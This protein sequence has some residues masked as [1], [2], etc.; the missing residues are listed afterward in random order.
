MF[1]CAGQR[2]LDDPVT[3]Q[4]DLPGQVTRGPLDVQPRGQPRLLAPLE[5]IHGIGQTA[6]VGPQHAV[7][8]FDQQMLRLLG[9]SPFSAMHDRCRGEQDDDGE[10]AQVQHIRPLICAVMSV[11]NRR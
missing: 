1:E 2:L 9:A 3:G 4:I 6:V 8:P 10:D 7:D 11:P 5:Q